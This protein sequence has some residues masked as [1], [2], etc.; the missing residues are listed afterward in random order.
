[1]PL[2]EQQ[3]ENVTK[4]VAALRSGKYQQ[5][6]SA[7]RIDYRFCCLGVAC[8]ISGVGQWEDGYYRCP[9]SE[10]SG[11]LPEDVQPMFGFGDCGPIITINGK[12]D[13]LAGHN[14][15]GATFSEIADA[16]EQQILGAK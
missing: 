7:L 16:L 14:D 4:L 8:D 12:A 13:R 10:E 2:T 5:A 3:R 6:R 11:Y 1:M 9:T 15:C